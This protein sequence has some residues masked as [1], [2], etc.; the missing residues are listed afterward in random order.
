[1]KSLH[2]S[3]QDRAAR[4]DGDTEP[5]R[6]KLSALREERGNQPAEGVGASE[7]DAWNSVMGGGAWR[8]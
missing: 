3:K 2:K 4:T 6:S 5:D 8:R 7:A 1:M